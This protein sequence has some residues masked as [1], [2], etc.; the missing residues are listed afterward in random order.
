MVEP[1]ARTGTDDLVA[2]EGRAVEHRDAIARGPR[3]G[4]NQWEGVRAP[5]RRRLGEGRLRRREIER[6]LQPPAD[7]PLRPFLP[8]EVIGGWRLQRTSC[9]QLL[10][11]I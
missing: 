1:V 11:R 6:D 3:L 8:H 2:C 9:R 4:G 7:A 5:Q 10:V